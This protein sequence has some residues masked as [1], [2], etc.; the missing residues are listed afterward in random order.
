MDYPWKDPPEEL[1][2]RFRLLH[3]PAIADVLDARGCMHQVLPPEI[4]PLADDMKVAGPAFTARGEATTTFTEDDIQF[5][6]AGWSQALAM[7]GWLAVIDASGDRTAAHWG[8]LLSNS[9]RT[10]GG[11]GVVV[12]GGVRDVDRI[13]PLGFPVFAGFRI[14]T[15]I[16]GR[17]RYVEFA[18]T[19]TIGGVEIHPWDYV[20]G[21]MNGVVIVPRDLVED[22]LAAAEVVVEREVEIRREL[23]A[24][25]N[26]IEVYARHG[27]F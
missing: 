3:A 4:M 18:G 27:S 17:W 9:A 5:A 6:F 7:P 1:A 26:P 24:G 16:R 19:L 22:V 11:S 14:P 13:L 25:A 10:L 23:V 15:D 12:N 8:E 2:E 21:D 20:F